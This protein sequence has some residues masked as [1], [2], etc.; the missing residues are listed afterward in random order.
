LS[1]GFR[2][3]AYEEGTGSVASPKWFDGPEEIGP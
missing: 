1:L 3:S 2:M